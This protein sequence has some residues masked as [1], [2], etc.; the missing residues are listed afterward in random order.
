MYIR[1]NIKIYYLYIYT[2]VLVKKVKS[3]VKYVN[4]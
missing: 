2:Y 3:G 4:K 1:E